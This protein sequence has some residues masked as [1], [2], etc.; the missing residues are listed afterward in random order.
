M[1][2]FNIK[3]TGVAMV[4]PFDKQGNVDLTSF[5]K[6]INHCIEGGCDYLVCLGT[7]SE[8]PTL[9]Q[10]EMFAVKEFTIECVENRV[11]IVLGMGGNDTRELINKITKY[12]YT[13]IAAILSVAPFYNKPN[14]KGLYTHFSQVANSSP[15]P[16]II[17]NVP[18][19]TGSNLNAETTLQL[20]EECNNIIGIKEASGNM[21]QCMEILRCKPKGFNVISGEDALTV[22]L[23]S[24]GAK[25]VISVTANAFPK[26][27][28]DMVNYCLKDNF[29]KAIPIHNALLPFTNAIFE[30]GNPVGIKSA[31]K[32]L[33]ITNNVV[34]L[35]LT[36]ASK[37]LSNKIQSIINDIK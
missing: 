1:K 20:A 23:M 37:S 35:P 16:V 26:Q 12:D 34:R 22:P 6:L 9:S 7:T 25:G 19:R 24:V 3:G 10:K 2:E 36:E 28:S 21:N 15:V 29:K 33:G 27:V 5:G 4:T 30:E 14:Q 31:L 32:T 13:N 17:Y 11:P 18:G 8:Y